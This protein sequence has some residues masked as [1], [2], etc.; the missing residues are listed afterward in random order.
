MSL[1]VV[2]GF[3]VLHFP[4]TNSFPAAEISLWVDYLSRASGFKWKCHLDLDEVF[5]ELVGK[6][7]EVSKCGP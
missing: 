2:S 3:G 5:R 6:R 1:G 7:W 4:V